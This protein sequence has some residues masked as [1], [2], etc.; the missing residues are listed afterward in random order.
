MKGI[1]WRPRRVS[2]W[3]LVGIAAAAVISITAV[4]CFPWKQTQPDGEQKLAAARLAERGMDRLREERL[5][6]G[7]HIDRQGAKE[8]RCE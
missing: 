4:E 7:H 2:R 6:R 1:Y 8:Q 3:V 5:S